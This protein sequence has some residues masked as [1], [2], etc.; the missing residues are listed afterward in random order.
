MADSTLR[1]VY[2]DDEPIARRGLERLLR[3]EEGVEV[4]AACTNGI[5]ALAAIETHSP[6]IVLIDIA[7]PGMTGVEVV[8]ALGDAHRPAV[9]FATA[10]DQY[11]IDA[12]EL[13][14]VD[15]L[16]KPFDE[17][18]FRVAFQRVR[19]R[20]IALRNE[21][22]S[23]KLDAVL[24]ALE[25]RPVADRLSIKDGDRVVLIPMSDVLWCEAEDNYVR[26][27]ATTGRH[28]VRMTMRG[29][30]ERLDPRRFAR[31]HRSYVVNL[32][33]VREFRPL[34]NGEYQVVLYDGVK[35][36]L[37]RTYRDTVLARMSPQ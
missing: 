1:V 31:I 5:E 4:V 11:A 19:Q 30:I 25:R 26:V 7:M 33:R 17:P 28:L 22:T 14:A 3:G 15:Y 32:S 21:E 29:L 2:A 34:S 23:A 36:V 27:H 12:F 6:H 13:H 9:V 8:R 35:L 20:L 37:S 18:R 24:S 10:F 16:L